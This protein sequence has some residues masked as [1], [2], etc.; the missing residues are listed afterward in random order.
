V[1][2]TTTNLTQRINLSD[3]A[4]WIAWYAAMR[5]LPGDPY[6]VEVKRFGQMVALVAHGVPTS[7]H[8]KVMDINRAD[9]ERLPE[10]VSFFRERCIPFRFDLNPFLAG[11]EAVGRLE[12]LGFELRALQSN[13]FGRPTNFLPSPP[14]GVSVQPVREHELGFFSDLYGRAYHDEDGESSFLARFRSASVTARWGQ[15]GWRFYMAFV[16][17]EPAG[18]GILHIKDGLA[19]LAGG[20]TLPEYR[21]RG[22]QRA[23]LE[24]RLSDAAAARSELVVSRCWRGSLSQRNMLRV[25]LRVGY[26]KEIWEPRRFE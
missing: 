6:G 1:V 9:I 8:N 18:G 13:L 4:L 25:G 21:G 14:H 11:D 5:N 3:T 26:V 15:P 12:S 10:I 7:A 2:L 17:D 20:A 24:R 19:T 22:C 16:D 23:L